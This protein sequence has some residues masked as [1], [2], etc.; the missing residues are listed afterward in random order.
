MGSSPLNCLEFDSLPEGIG[1]NGTSHSSGRSVGFRRE[2]LPQGL[3]ALASLR[4]KAGRF[5]SV[6]WTGIEIAED[7]LQLGQRS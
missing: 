4:Y 2:A 6:S 5:Y 7:R 3:D 1:Q